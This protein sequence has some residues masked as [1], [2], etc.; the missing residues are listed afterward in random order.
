MPV[1]QK[2]CLLAACWARALPPNMSLLVW[3][4]LIDTALPIKPRTA[5]SEKRRTRNINNLLED[6]DNHFKGK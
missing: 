6:G 5:L 1:V 2:T 3:L 4:A